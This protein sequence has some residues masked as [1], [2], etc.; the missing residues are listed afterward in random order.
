MNFYSQAFPVRD[1]G[2]TVLLCFFL[3][4]ACCLPGT[5]AVSPARFNHVV[6]APYYSH[7]AFH[8]VSENHG[9]LLQYLRY[10][11]FFLARHISCYS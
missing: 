6:S 4:P 2:S 9:I 10:A 3:H 7:I 11:N 5:P 8:T 1:R